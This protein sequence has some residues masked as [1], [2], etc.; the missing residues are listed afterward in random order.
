MSLPENFIDRKTFDRDR[1]IFTHQLRTA[2]SKARLVADALQNIS[3]QLRHRQIT[4]EQAKQ[5]IEE[6][7]L[8]QFTQLA[9]KGG[10]S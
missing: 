10:A 9:P 1:E 8:A 5:Y 2:V 4:T 3:I 7:G 6:Q